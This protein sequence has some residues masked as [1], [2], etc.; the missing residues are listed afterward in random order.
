MFGLFT[1]ATCDLTNFATL[2]D[3][4]TRLIVVDV[5]GGLRSAPG[6]LG[7]LSGGLAAHL[8]REGNCFSGVPR[9]TAEVLRVKPRDRFE[10]YRSS[11]P[12]R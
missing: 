11:S 10:S 7:E 9:P 6:G 12:R 5:V 1:H 3:W 8:I 4:P 2:E